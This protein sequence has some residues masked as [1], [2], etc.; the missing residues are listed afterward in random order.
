MVLHVGLFPDLFVLTLYIASKLIVRLNK[1]ICPKKTRYLK[2]LS[3]KIR[4]VRAKV[5]FDTYRNFVVSQNV[6]FAL[7]AN[8]IIPFCRF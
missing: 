7:I 3:V 6:L 1:Q 8:S 4:I 5:S 2:G